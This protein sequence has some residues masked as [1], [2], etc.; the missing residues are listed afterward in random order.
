M[1]ERLKKI[2][3]AITPT[4][5]I[6]DNV[7]PS[8]IEKP[9][10]SKSTE[11]VNI[12]VIWFE[13]V[14]DNFKRKSLDT[15]SEQDNNINREAIRVSTNPLWDIF[16]SP[17]KDYIAPPEDT[18][19]L[20]NDI[21][22]TIVWGEPIFK[23]PDL[24]NNSFVKNIWETYSE[25]NQVSDAEVL[26][27]KDA[28]LSYFASKFQSWEW[29]DFAKNVD[30]YKSYQDQYTV[31]RDYENFFKNLNDAWFDVTKIASDKEILNTDA[32]S[33]L[34][35]Y[36]NQ[37]AI[38]NSLNTNPEIQALTWDEK[39]IA[40]S[41]SLDFVQQE[42][43]KKAKQY[44]GLYS[45]WKEVTDE[46]AQSF[47]DFAQ[48]R[49][50]EVIN[51]EQLVREDKK[52]QRLDFYKK[53]YP[54]DYQSKFDEYNKKST[55]ADK[56]NEAAA[57]DRF[58]DINAKI[59]KANNDWDIV[60]KVEYEQSLNLNIN[61]RSERNQ[62]L[63]AASDQILNLKWNNAEDQAQ[64]KSIW[65][66]L[67]NNWRKSWEIQTR[68]NNYVGSNIWDYATQA[69]AELAWWKEFLQKEMID[70][71]KTTY[72]SYWDISTIIKSWNRNAIAGIIADII[73]EP[74]QYL[75]VWWKKEY[76]SVQQR[77]VPWKSWIDF[78]S[79]QYKEYARTKSQDYHYYTPILDN[80]EW[81]VWWVAN[82]LENTVV[83]LLKKP[84]EY[85]TFGNTNI[86]FNFSVS[87]I[88]WQTNLDNYNKRW[89]SV[90]EAYNNVIN[91]T[92]EYWEVIP[93]AYFLFKNP[94]SLIWEVWMMA[95]KAWTAIGKIKQIEQ[96]ATKLW[97]SERIVWLLGNM[98]K[99]SE[100]LKATSIYTKWEDLINWW[101][102]LISSIDDVLFR[103]WKVSDDLWL[104]AWRSKDIMYK[105]TR[106]EI[107]STFWKELL[108]NTIQDK[109]IW[110]YIFWRT[111]RW[112]TNDD[113]NTDM[114]FTLWAST[115]GSLARWYS[116]FNNS[117]RITEDILNNDNA[118]RT[119]FETFL[120]DWNIDYF[121]DVNWV[122]QPKDSSMAKDF[123]NLYN[124]YNTWLSA[125]IHIMRNE[126]WIKLLTETLILQDYMKW[127]KELVKQW[128]PEELIKYTTLMW[129]ELEWA[130]NWTVSFADVIA[131]QI[132][133]NYNKWFKLWVWN[134]MVIVNN[135]T[136]KLIK[137]PDNT[138]ESVLKIDTS[139][140]Y[141]DEEI[142]IIQQNIETSW[143]P[144]TID[145]LF[146]KT[147]SWYISSLAKAKDIWWL[148]EAELKNVIEKL[149]LNQRLTQN[150]A[151]SVISDLNLTDINCE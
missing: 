113:A 133:M 67:L 25:I 52:N 81:A 18:S 104:A 126:K 30:K 59:L 74:L 71:W 112:Y 142:K 69:E 134:S 70:K 114:W 82:L 35:I 68:F 106:P 43:I 10:I 48:Q 121:K 27:N 137:N 99:A 146:I 91:Y 110:E 89:I 85:L 1:F 102:K 23:L 55:L 135:W 21:K 140:I 14:F 109:L 95:W 28:T 90:S 26:K 87:S 117:L 42:W 31:N 94:L 103:V 141:N 2:W 125:W 5:P 116:V 54:S 115:I 150:A 80:I 51:I 32:M 3:N 38:V 8:A 108:D 128:I 40:M 88:L 136:D 151:E 15:I 12:P 11:N 97:N 41:N 130:K 19:S 131:K 123:F 139:K 132:D 122:L 53:Y 22:T 24:F 78:M 6:N 20:R 75:D 34:W 149:P 65:L 127:A 83:S 124:E 129:K 98:T 33:Q 36:N 57:K 39:V 147:D 58:P 138:I 92:D 79:E 119:G 17:K 56:A 120:K 49:S 148:P 77:W 45:N 7:E 93:Q 50:T 86:W 9:T 144:V 61:N 84:Q 100:F 96:L 105:A 47:I 46:Q 76:I 101:N 72:S 111:N 143:V 107:I 29:W 63:I 37:E 62:N 66:Q 44:L 60:K 13:N 4:V 145:N 16:N 118:M 73:T 64:I